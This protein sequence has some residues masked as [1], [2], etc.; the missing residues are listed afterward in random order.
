L[1]AEEVENSDKLVKLQVLV[2]DEKRQIL[3]G[4]RKSYEPADLVGRQVIVV[5]NLK[6]RKMAG[7]ESQGMILAADGPDGKAILLTPE[8]EAPEG[9]SVH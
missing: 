9:S 2:G 4:I 3:A 7:L 6:P 8:A 1:E 5:C